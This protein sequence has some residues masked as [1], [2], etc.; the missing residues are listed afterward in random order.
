MWWTLPGHSLAWVLLGFGVIGSLAYARSLEH[1][2]AGSATAIVW[3]TQVS[4]ASLV[5]IIVLGDSV[6]PGWALP[7]LAAATMAM[8][9]C[10]SLDNNSGPRGHTTGRDTPSGDPPSEETG[11]AEQATP[12]IVL[13]RITGRTTAQSPTP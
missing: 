5:G 2:S 6:R 8:I 13:A 11:H 1:R 4:L 9:I 3:I 10:L 7:A 12:S